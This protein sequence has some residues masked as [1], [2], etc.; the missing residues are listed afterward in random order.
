MTKNF[1]YFGDRQKQ[2][3][4]ENKVL[5]GSSLETYWEIGERFGN[6]LGT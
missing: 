5:L 3:E 6:T 4:T 2:H 1:V